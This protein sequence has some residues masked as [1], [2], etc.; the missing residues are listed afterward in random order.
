[1]PLCVLP[2]L[3][4]PFEGDSHGTLGFGQIHQ[5]KASKYRLFPSVLRYSTVTTQDRTIKYLVL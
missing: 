3:S 4:G 5:P 1:M 2:C